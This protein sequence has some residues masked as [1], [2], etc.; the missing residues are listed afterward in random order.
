MLN[1]D[2]AGS[3]PAKLFIQ[4]GRAPVCVWRARALAASADGVTQAWT[5]APR[6]RA[7]NDNQLAWPYLAFADDWYA[8]C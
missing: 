2:I 8:A 3:A 7:A 6:S 1:D 5:C 4:F